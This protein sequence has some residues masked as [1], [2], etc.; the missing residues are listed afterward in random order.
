[1]KCFLCIEICRS[2]LASYEQSMHICSQTHFNYA[3]KMFPVLRAN[4]QNTPFTLTPSPHTFK[5]Q[6]K[7][8]NNWAIWFCASCVNHKETHYP[9]RMEAV[10]S[11][12]LCRQILWV[13]NT[14]VPHNQPLHKMKTMHEDWINLRE[15]IQA[16]SKNHY[17]Q[18]KILQFM[19]LYQKQKNKRIPGGKREIKK[20]L[21]ET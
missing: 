6:R 14:A 7:F 8:S 16:D 19:H 3:H 4:I 2:P 17:Q 1:M 12:A 5:A 21:S 13:S 15:K 20:M 11:M 9:E 18:Q 10:L